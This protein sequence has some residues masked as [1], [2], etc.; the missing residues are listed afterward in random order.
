MRNLIW[1][2][3]NKLLVIKFIKRRWTDFFWECNCECWW[4]KIVS[5]MSLRNWDTKS[6]WCA[7]KNN[8]NKKTHWMTKTRF[9]KIYCWIKS[10]CDNINDTAYKNYWNRWIKYKWNSFEDFKKDMYEKYLEH[11]K[12][13]WEKETSI[14]RIDVNWNYCKYNCRWITVK[15]QSNNKR[16]THIVKYNW[17][18][19]SIKEWSIELWIPYSIFLYR[20]NIQKMTIDKILLFKNK[21]YVRY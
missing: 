13:F 5:W 9:Y 1:M 17:I 15:W 2:K 10:R 6:C 14:D 7:Y 3:F 20:I 4:I 16:T 18:F 21:K 8:W 11:C 12:E 19:K